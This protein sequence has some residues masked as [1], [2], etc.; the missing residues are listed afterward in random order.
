MGGGAVYNQDDTAGGECERC[1]HI[2]HRPPA[3]GYARFNE[4]VNIVGDSFQS[5][6]KPTQASKGVTAI[7]WRTLA[8]SGSRGGPKINSRTLL[9]VTILSSSMTGRQKHSD[10]REGHDK[11]C[12]P[13]KDLQVTR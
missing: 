11:G 10:S 1:R 4:H 12:S 9:G 3:I 2:K 13:A 6:P 8:P 5:A 7:A